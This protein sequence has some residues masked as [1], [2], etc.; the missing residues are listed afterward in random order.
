MLNPVPSQAAGFLPRPE[1]ET[2]HPPSLAQVGNVGTAWPGRLGGLLWCLSCHQ[3]L[4]LVCHRQER[5]KQL[6]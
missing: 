2:A 6:V 4:G 3:G 5:F 1:K